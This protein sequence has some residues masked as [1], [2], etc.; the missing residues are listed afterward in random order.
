MIEGPA[1]TRDWIAWFP[2]WYNGPAVESNGTIFTGF[3]TAKLGVF[4][5]GF[6]V[7]AT[8]LEGRFHKWQR[9][10]YMWPAVVVETTRPLRGLGLLFDHDGRI[11]WCGVPRSGSKPLK[12]A[13]L[14]AGLD[15]IEV[16]VRGWAAAIPVPHELLGEAVERVPKSVV[17]YNSWARHT[18]GWRRLDHSR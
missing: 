11:A 3:S 9:V 4:T 14:A 13:L 1:A 10:D 15:V 16:S 6:S 7:F 18:G 5:G 17:N 8:P 2:A 12:D